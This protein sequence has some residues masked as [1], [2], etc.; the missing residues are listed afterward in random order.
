MEALA[1]STPGT[2]AAAE[3]MDVDVNEQMLAAVAAGD[4]AGVAGALA[5]GASVH[6]TTGG[7]LV[8]VWQATACIHAL[9]QR[10]VLLLLW[11]LFLCLHAIF[12]NAMLAAS[13][14]THEPNCITQLYGLKGPEPLQ[15]A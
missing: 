9:Q 2:G 12:S 13:A 14:V 5:A 10:H 8:H 4:A 1:V 7:C 6:A 11:Q 3:Q 15:Q